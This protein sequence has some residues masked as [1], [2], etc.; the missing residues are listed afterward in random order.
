MLYISTRNRIDT[1]TAYRALHEVNA[2]DGG[3]FVP[4]HLPEF[5]SDELEALK[6][7]SCG[8]VIANILNLFFG[9]RLK[10][11]DVECEIGRS[12]FKQISMQH[13]LLMAEAWRNPEAS[14]G[15]LLKSLYSLATEQK[16]MGKQPVGWSCIGIKIALLFGL[17]SGIDD[18]SHELD[19]AVTAGDFSDLAAIQ[20]AKKMGLPLRLTVCACN[21]NSSFWDLVNRGEFLCSTTDTNSA[22]PDYLECFFYASLGPD[23]VLQYLDS[24]E[25]KKMFTIDASQQEEL[26]AHVFAAVVSN[27]RVDAVSS[28]M[29][30]TNGYALDTDSALA[31]GGLQDYRSSTGASVNTIILSKRR[32]ARVKE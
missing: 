18:V 7:Q 26:S 24:V 12:P 16:S 27:N 17:Y 4:F 13:R 20:Y 14:Y 23:A 31:Y 9:V 6:T 25:R 21:E 32:P 2:P 22:R 11:W 29:F 10:C 5:T 15:Y 1:Y 28:N 8:E 19:I 3:I 30:R